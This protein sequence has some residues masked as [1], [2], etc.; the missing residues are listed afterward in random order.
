MRNIVIVA[1]A[2]TFCAG[3]IGSTQQWYEHS[4]TPAFEFRSSDP[5]KLY[6]VDWVDRDYPYSSFEYPQDE[7]LLCIQPHNAGDTWCERRVTDTMNADGTRTAAVE[8]QP[9]PAGSVV[10]FSGTVVRL[11]KTGWA[12]FDATLTDSS[13][14][15]GRFGDT[16]VWLSGLDIL[17]LARGYSEFT[18]ANADAFRSIGGEQMLEIYKQGQPGDAAIWR[19]SDMRSEEVNRLEKVGEVE[20]KVTY[21]SFHSLKRR[22]KSF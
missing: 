8:V 7:K 6:L 21:T 10:K 11:S 12:A 14:F 13:H 17:Y 3:C 19:C 16:R 15:E 5:I 9:L 4:C 20:S 22:T 1:L 18:A 2:I